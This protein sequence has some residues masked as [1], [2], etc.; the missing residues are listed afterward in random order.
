MARRKARAGEADPRPGEPKFYL[1]V[2]YPYPS[3]GMHVGHGR[4]YTVP[5]VVARFQRMRGKN[6]LYPMGF[7]CTGTPVVGISERIKRRDPKALWLYGELYQVPPETLERFTRP[8]VIVDYFSKEYRRNMTDLGLAIDWRRTFKTIEPRYKRFTEWH[9]RRLM[10]AGLVHRGEHPVKWCPNDKNAVGDHDLLQGDTA[11]IVEYTLLPFRLE[12]GTV[13]PAATL[14]PET[15]Y[16]TTNLWVKPEEAYARVRVN[17][18]ETW[19]VSN[20]A[21]EKM[22]NQRFEVEVQGEVAGRQL[23]GRTVETP[24]TGA[25]VPVLPGAFVDPKVATGVVFSVPAHAPYDHAGL[26]DL[27]R[28]PDGLAAVVAP[29]EPIPIIETEGY[30][31]VPAADLCRRMKV[32]GQSDPKLNEATETLYRDELRKGRMKA[33]LPE[34]GGLPV[35]EARDRVKARLGAPALHDF[36]GGPVVCRCNTECFVKLLTDQWFLKYSD[37]EWKRRTKEAMGRIHFVPSEITAQFLHTVDWLEDWACTRRVGLGTPFQW[38]PGQIVEPLSDSV[39]YM[40]YYTVSH[41]LNRIP[42]SKL[43]DALFDYVFRGRGDPGRVGVPVALLKKMRAEF[44]YWYPYDYRFSAK[45][46]VGNHLTFQ[47]FH[48]AALF[49]KRHRPKGIVVFGIG[50]LDGAKMSSSK[51][52]VVRLG[53]ALKKHG[54]DVV[55]FFLVSSAEPWQDFDWREEAV[56]GAARALEA[57]RRLAAEGLR[58]RPAGKPSRELRSRP[59]ASLRDVPALEPIDRWLLSKAQRRA[60]AAAGAMERFQTRQA[61]QEALYGLLED[62]RW[63]RRR[64]DPR[65][66]GARYALHHAAR[67]WVLLMAPFVPKTAASLWRKVSRKPVEGERYPA[68]DRR[69]LD[70]KAEAAESLVGR[71]ASDLQEIL[72][73]TGAAPKRVVLYVAPDWSRKLLRSAL[74]G[75]EMKGLMA[76]AQRD[77]ALK[78]RMAEVAKMA[79]KLQ[80]HIHSLGPQTAKDLAALDEPRI[81]Q[82]ALPFLQREFRCPVELQEAEAPREDP[83]GRA[84]GALPFRPAIWLDS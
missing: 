67:A 58:Q 16:G 2:A 76:E 4:T 45:D 24:L 52:N 55:R 61:A 14:R 22:R 75:G 27:K 34:V 5:D 73:V 29:L 7:H 6:A 19:L 25:R 51:G 11:A 23:V 82:S 13:L 64:T 20:P 31:A 44:L 83:A 53:D 33:G 26:A 71:V 56:Q 79:S 8:E 40:A 39:I 37:P 12:D 59:G 70:P 68:S 49:P 10:A 72:R 84:K 30:G 46:L 43:S 9:Y 65:R 41:H 32:S 48:H 17:G 81:L 21:V 60:E 35:A 36:T 69:L 47:V 57:F 50:L 38:D 42:L 1:T 28:S 15:L 62:V 18:K 74:K 54:S 80:G 3:G 66:P 63:F 78:E 77:P